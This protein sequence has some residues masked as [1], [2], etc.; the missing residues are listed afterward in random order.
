MRFAAVWKPRI[1]EDYQTSA[2]KW[3]LHI[4]A[5]TIK[6]QG[7]V[8]SPAYEVNRD[9]YLTRTSYTFHVKSGQQVEKRICL[10]G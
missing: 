2:D 10:V 9:K 5:N 4:L 3:T 1:K 8:G 7:G 6:A